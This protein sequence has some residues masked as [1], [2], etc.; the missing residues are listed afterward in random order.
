MQNRHALRSSQNARVLSGVARRAGG[1][2]VRANLKASRALER[3]FRLAS[4]K[5]FWAS[6]EHDVTARIAAQPRDGVVVD[7]GGGRRCVYAR[8]IPADQR[9]RVIAVDVSAEELELND[10][11]AERHVADVGLGLPF[12]PAS[13]DLVV[14][15]A[16]LEHVAD[17]PAAA[18]N[19]ARVVKPGGRRSTSC[20]VAMHRSRSPLEHFRSAP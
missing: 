4:D 9:P 18:R 12:P 14:S 1:A 2:L 7:V 15:R 6:F 19:I 20:R 3:H 10:E 5:P 11:V 16:V 13:V 8:H 17:V